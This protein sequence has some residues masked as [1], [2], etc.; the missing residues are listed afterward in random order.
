MGRGAAGRCAAGGRCPA[1][2][3][4]DRGGAAAAHCDAGEDG[5]VQVKR[6]ATGPVSASN[7]ARVCCHRAVQ[8]RSVWAHLLSHSARPVTPF[9][10]SWHIGEVIADVG[11]SAG[12][13]KSSLINMLTNN[14]S[15]AKVSKTPGASCG[16]RSHSFAYRAAQSGW[17]PGPCGARQARRSASTT[18]W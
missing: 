11:L 14:K 3:A 4:A 12:P 1:G 5:G 2:S 8:R 15:L 9:R 16:C 13:G 17:T 6:R 7:P 18:F 10:A